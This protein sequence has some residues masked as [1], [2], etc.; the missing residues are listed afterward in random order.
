MKVVV[1]VLLPVGSQTV[2]EVPTVV[3]H[4]GRRDVSLASACADSEN[5]FRVYVAG[6]KKRRQEGHKNFM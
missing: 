4:L 6:D 5:E 1:V 2:A 3:I